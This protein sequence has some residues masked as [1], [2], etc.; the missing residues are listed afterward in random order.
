LN[1]INHD[2]TLTQDIGFT[3]S[4]TWTSAANAL[5][6]LNLN[7][8]WCAVLG[9]AFLGDQLPRRT[10]V[11]LVLAICCMMLIFVPDIVDRRNGGGSSEE[12]VVEGE[13]EE[14][15]QSLSSTKGNVTACLT[16]IILAVYISIVRKAGLKNNNNNNNSTEHDSEENNDADKKE[17]NL[18]GATSLAAILVAI[19]ALIV[20]RG[21]VLPDASW[22]GEQGD[23]DGE[24]GELWQFWLAMIADGMALGIL[25]VC[26]TIAPRLAKGAEVALVLLLEIILGPLWVFLA[27]RDV[28][29]VWTLVGGSMYVVVVLLWC[30]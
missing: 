1:N 6:L 9:R 11:A 18:V 12:V 20:Q 23:G 10:I 22:R 27:Y 21:N 17:V 8:L 16:G 7:P 26:L 25:F 30:K 13:D 15:L 29:S 24:G 19:I 14:D 28:P 3:F 2:H 4:L 5:L